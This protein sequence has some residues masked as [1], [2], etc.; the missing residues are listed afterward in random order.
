MQYLL[1][2]DQYG[3]IREHETMI[4][5][6]PDQIVH[7]NRAVPF[8][9]IT[10]LP[11]EQLPAVISSLDTKSSW[12]L[13]RFKDQKY[14][15]Q[16]V[17]VESKIRLRFIEMGG[18]PSLMHPIYFFLGR[19]K[20][21]EEHPLNIGYS[22]KLEDLNKLTVSFSY[23]DTMLSFDEENRRLSGASYQNPLCDQIFM[24]DELNKLFESPLF[25]AQIPLAVEA[26][27]WTMPLDTLVQKID[28]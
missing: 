1:F 18:S 25:P 22:L 20:R 14:L 12:G 27:L 23:G 11:A 21:F 16:R 19:N 15:K 10:A 28:R 13:D 6:V 5:K 24:L 8:R 7:Y 17:E 4:Q 26:H 9:T 3:I 2:R